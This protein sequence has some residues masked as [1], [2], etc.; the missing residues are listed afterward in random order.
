MT[1]KKKYVEKQTWM[2]VFGQKT[3]LSFIMGNPELV[4][5]ILRIE[6]FIF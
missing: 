2:C 1:Y 3:N 4:L 6:K 5:Y